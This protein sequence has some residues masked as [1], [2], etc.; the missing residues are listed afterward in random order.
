[1]RARLPSGSTHVSALREV[2][3][4]PVAACAARRA[5]STSSAGAVCVATFER[6][7]WR[8]PVA[9]R[10]TR[11]IATEPHLV[12]AVLADEI[13]RARCSCSSLDERGNRG[14]HEGREV[15]C[16]LRTLEGRAR[17]N[18]IAQG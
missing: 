7:P 6:S 13:R 9:L 18:R 17:A 2:E 8:A 3:P 16:V 5:D 10:A 14:P 15:P 4:A 11:G 1:M 12:V